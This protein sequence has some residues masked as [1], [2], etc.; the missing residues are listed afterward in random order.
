MAVD[1]INGVLTPNRFIPIDTEE[2]T[3]LEYIGKLTNKTNEMVSHINVIDKKIPTKLNVSDYQNDMLINR[4]I[5]ENGDFTGSWF[6]V[7]SPHDLNPSLIDYELLK[8]LSS[9]GISYSSLDLIG[10]R[11][12]WK[13]IHFIGD[14]ITHGANCEDI[15]MN[16]WCGIIRRCLAIDYQT[17][18]HGYETIYSP[19]Q[20]ANGKYTSSHYCDTVGSWSMNEDYRSISLCNM[21]SVEKG[22]ILKITPNTNSKFC[23]VLF[24]SVDDG[25]SFKVYLS[26]N[27]TILTT[28]NTNVGV[29]GVFYSNQIDLQNANG[30]L[31]IMIEKTDSKL[32][33]I[34]GVQ[35]YD[36]ESK[37]MLQNY[38][39]SGAKL[40]DINTSIIPT[41]CNTSLAF[42]AL[43]HNDQW[44][45][46]VSSFSNKINEFMNQFFKFKTKVVVLDF[47][48]D[49]NKTVLKNELKRLSSSLDGI[50]ID[51][52]PYHNQIG[53]MSDESHPSTYGHQ[54]IASVV[55][56]KLGLG[57]R[58]KGG[59]FLYKKPVNI[60]LM[61]NAE[62]LYNT[63]YREGKK[64]TFNLGISQSRTNGDVVAIF[65]KPLNEIKFLS[66]GEEYTILKSGLV[67]YNGETKEKHELRGCYTI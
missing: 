51:F 22:A 57:V 62:L 42:F 5:N 35:Y 40:K 54:V 25:G 48:W 11:F 41:L 19:I 15:E 27:P 7:S 67:V 3:G 32:T 12:G 37:P 28:V 17:P 63:S 44:D 61:N 6:G 10:D 4:K 60:G 33:E 14:S 45:E 50:Y 24:N 8:S 66:G 21:S 34:V 47:I 26:N 36:D 13:S 59:S 43:G 38:A 16:S 29:D 55:A 31:Q 2:L 52:S 18:N 58:S 56:Q 39:R 20:N 53:F 1:K 46:D 9:D 65:P 64:V 23:R 49:E 30:E